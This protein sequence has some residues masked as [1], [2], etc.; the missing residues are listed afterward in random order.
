MHKC[1][2]CGATLDEKA[3]ECPECHTKIEAT[4]AQGGEIAPGLPSTS[5]DVAGAIAAVKA[6]VDKFASDKPELA[7][8]L[9]GILDELKRIEGIVAADAQQGLPEGAAARVRS[10]L[11]TIEGLTRARSKTDQVLGRMRELLGLGPTADVSAAEPVA[12][13]AAGEQVAKPAPDDMA[14]VMAECATVCLACADACAACVAAGCDAPSRKACQEACDACAMACEGCIKACVGQAGMERCLEAC[15]ECLVKC[16]ECSAACAEGAYDCAEKCERC[17]KHCRECA[18][19]CGAKSAPVEPAAGEAA[20]ALREVLFAG[21]DFDPMAGSFE[22]CVKAAMKAKG[23]PE[24]NARALC[25]FIKRQ[26]GEI[27]SLPQDARPVEA[28]ASREVDF[29]AA[30]AEARVVV[31]AR[32]IPI[33]NLLGQAP[34]KLSA[35]KVYRDEKTGASYAKGLMR[36]IVPGM[37]KDMLAFIKPEAVA[38]SVG[39][40]N[41]IPIRLDH[42]E[43]GPD[44]KPRLVLKEKIGKTQR[45]AYIGADGASYVTGHVYDPKTIERM[46]NAQLGGDED[47]YSCSFRGKVLAER[48]AAKINGVEREIE[49]LSDIPVIRS[50]DLV[51]EGALEG[52][53]FVGEAAA[54][55]RSEDDEEP[56]AP[57]GEERTTMYD[58]AKALKKAIALAR[59]LAMEASY[60]AAVVEQFRIWA[61]EQGKAPLM[62]EQEFEAALGDEVVTAKLAELAKKLEPAPAATAAPS[63]PAGMRIEGGPELQEHMASI[64]EGAI[65]GHESHHDTIQRCFNAAGKRLSVNGEVAMAHVRGMARFLEVYNSLGKKTA[66]KAK[67]GPKGEAAERFRRYIEDPDERAKVA[68]AIVLQDFSASLSAASVSG[69]SLAGSRILDME[70]AVTTVNVANA[71]ADQLQ[72]V[73]RKRSANILRNPSRQA[74]V[75]VAISSS[76]DSDNLIAFHVVGGQAPAGIGTV[77]ETVDIPT[78]ASPATEVENITPSLYAGLEEWTE[79]AI[80][81]DTAGV[82]GSRLEEL[83]DQVDWQFYLAVM[84]PWAVNG[85]MNDGVPIFSTVVTNPNYTQQQYT[86]ARFLTT[87]ELG[88]NQVEYSV[89]TGTNAIPVRWVPTAACCSTA[90]ATILERDVRS[91][92]A[93]DT[94]SRARN[95]VQTTTTWRGMGIFAQPNWTNNGQTDRIVVFGDPKLGPIGHVV[96]YEGRRDAEAWIIDARNQGP[97]ISKNSIYLKVR[98]GF[99]YAPVSR[100]NVVGIWA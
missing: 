86:W 24:K 20:A 47:F 61:D 51:D 81:N 25:A 80:K 32:E 12:P 69:L 89:A 18:E 9:T 90:M 94:A 40:L 28:Q 43:K 58:K 95:P 11:Q 29:A 27:A 8:S 60:D 6:L 64:L 72:K 42:P 68:G 35:Y 2:K 77:A 82:F 83:Q 53:G 15:A 73:M 57:A 14:A 67:D 59:G 44:G 33:Q 71:T 37:R 56:A 62:T 39:R 13:P 74:P 31:P 41:A 5:P 75:D 22:D 65:T 88:D 91:L 23:I 79:W 7:A 100:R 96:Y 36:A 78:L 4:Q 84:N 48:V 66:G 92:E 34:Q 85:N 99:G 10:A 30:L 21:S 76:S 98:R 19:A 3:T 16:R 97:N 87:L 70:A 54:S 63:A 17:E 1:P 50:L 55:L 49:L 45:D 38:A 26:A 46:A 52:A 93:P